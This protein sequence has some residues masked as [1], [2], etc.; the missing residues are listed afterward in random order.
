MGLTHVASVHC[1]NLISFVRAE[2][3]NIRPLFWWVF[4]G[5]VMKKL[6][7]YVFV[8]VIMLSFLW[9]GVRYGTAKCAGN[10]AVNNAQGQIEIIMLERDVNA[11]TISRGVG[12]IRR[13]LHEKYTIA[14]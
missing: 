12:D 10:I 14:E 8:F 5:I 2:I 6:Y 7:F 1:V 3:L 13:V 11:E 9:I 4:V